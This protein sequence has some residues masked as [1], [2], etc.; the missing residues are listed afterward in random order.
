VGVENGYG[1]LVIEFGIIGLLLWIVLGAS[2]SISAWKVVKQLRGSPWFPIGFVVFWFSFLLFFPM[3]YTGLTF[4]QDFL[5]N[6]YFWILI[7]IL[8]RLPSLALATQRSAAQ[9][10]V[11]G[12]PGLSDQTA[13]QTTGD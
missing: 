5:V 8:Y 4:Y 11:L 6:A 7:G 9:R 3:G 13:V 12:S 10:S 2:V 1:Q